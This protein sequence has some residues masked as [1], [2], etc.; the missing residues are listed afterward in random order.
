M[1]QD[2]GFIVRD[3]LGNPISAAMLA[4]IG[5]AVYELWVRKCLVMSG[6]TNLREAHNQA[7]RRVKAH[8]QA[9]T[10]AKLEPFLTAMEREVVRMGRNTKS[11]VPRSASVVDYRY[12][13]GFEALLGY[14]YLK[15]DQARLEE[16]LRI[17]E[18]G[19]RKEPE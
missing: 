12:S 1:K 19:E 8:A 3:N 13:T 2:S 4:Y 14:L 10:L 15:G 16:L 18:A 9:E 11:T 7:V 5:D 17:S 6:K